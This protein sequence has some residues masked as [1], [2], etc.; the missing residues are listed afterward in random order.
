MA[1]FPFEFEG[2]FESGST[3]EWTSLEGTQLTV[4]DYKDLSRQRKWGV[5]YRGAF[6]LQAEFGIDTD[7]YVRTIDIN[8]EEDED[9]DIKFM[10]YI[11]KDLEASVTTEVVL[12]QHLPAVAAVGLRIES[13]GDIKLGIRSSTA[14]LTTSPIILQRGVYYTVEMEMDTT[15]GNTCTARISE[16]GIEV[17]T[18]NALSTARTTEGWLGIIGVGSGSLAD[19]SGTLTIDSFVY[20]SSRINSDHQRFP[21][22]QIITKTAHAFVGLGHISDLQL[23][24][25]DGT[26]CVL[27]VYDTDAA[28]TTTSNLVARVTNNVSAETANYEGQRPIE[29]SKG[30]YVVLSGTSPRAIVTIGAAPAYG[31]ESVLRN[32]GK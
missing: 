28:D 21:R 17:T 14:P 15:G 25:G 5:P 7:S 16:L 11:S 10:L 30:A 22:K 13:G 8:A 26:D 20:D 1:R 29:V 6:A 24:A 4:R 19:I 9:K 18:T 12:M 3:D 27:E 32:Y 2:N 23:V 31:S